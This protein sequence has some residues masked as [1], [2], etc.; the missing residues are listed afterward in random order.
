[1]RNPPD[2]GYVKYL[3]GFYFSRTENPTYTKKI[4][5]G[6]LNPEGKSL[7]SQNSSLRLLKPNR[8][9]EKLLP[10][11]GHQPCKR[12]NAYLRYV[13]LMWCIQRQMIAPLIYE[14]Y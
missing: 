12:L 3:K 1:M 4:E 11:Y 14:A 8:G 13:F 6:L 7:F 5:V 10:F 2:S 9:S